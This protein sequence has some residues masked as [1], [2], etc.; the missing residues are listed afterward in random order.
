MNPPD[1][2]AA[3]PSIRDIARVAKVHFTTVGL[4]LH[5]DPRIPA[6][7]CNRLRLLAEKMGYRTN[8]L[9]T[10]HMKGVRSGRLRR[11]Y[12]PLAFCYN[13]QGHPDGWRE[14]PAGLYFE[15]ARQRAE[16]FGYTLE[17]FN[18]SK[19]G[20]THQR[21]SNILLTRGIHGIV[22]T[23]FQRVI[24]HIALE[25]NQFS[26]V[27]I[28]PNPR[29]PRCDTVCNHQAQMVRV[30]FRQAH[31]RGYRRIGLVVQREVDER[32]GD[33][34][35][36]GYL[37][38]QSFIPATRRLQPLRPADLNFEEFR[39]WLQREKPDA[40]ICL[41]GFIV[42]PWLARMNLPVPEKMGFIDLNQMDDT[43]AIAGMRKNFPLIGS[44]AVDQVVGMLE[45]NL[46]GI[47][48]LP[49]LTLVSGKWIDGKSLRPLPA[50]VPNPSDLIG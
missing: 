49:K 19:P 23:G 39:S 18:L 48:E 46:R 31:Q 45:R 29:N 33:T 32:L 1:P 26:T 21:W 35:L 20:F 25:W 47:P 14:G 16:S 44:A 40:I 50:G 30:S 11:P 3:S 37:V 12:L 22:L 28:D 6:S 41:G 9:L 38:E 27:R 8:P 42:L 17:P 13:W 15:G 24:D 36:S 7:T 2:L 5:N 34:F 4:A 10:A 43:G